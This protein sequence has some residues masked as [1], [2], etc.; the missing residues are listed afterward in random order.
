[1]NTTQTWF[2]IDRHWS[3][4]VESEDRVF[5]SSHRRSTYSLGNLISAVAFFLKTDTHCYFINKESKI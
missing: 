5:S 4:G 3:S 1:M 2:I